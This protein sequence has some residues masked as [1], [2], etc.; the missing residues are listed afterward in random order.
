MVY[1]KVSG[2]VQKEF[3]SIIQTLKDN[4]QTEEKILYLN[5]N[6]IINEIYLKTLFPKKEIEKILNIYFQQ[7]ILQED[8]SII[9]SEKIRKELDSKREEINKKVQKEFEKVGI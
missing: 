5:Y 7:E 4:Y 9:L 1:E 2:K 6:K 3:E 8:R